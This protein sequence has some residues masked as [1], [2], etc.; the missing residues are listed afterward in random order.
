MPATTRTTSTTS[1]TSTTSTTSPR[2]VFE[3]LLAAITSRSWAELPD[4]YAEDSVVEQPFQLPAPLR[5]QG[6]AQLREHFAA[7]TRLPIEL[8]TRNVVV[9]ETLD[10][11]VVVGE[12]DYDVHLPATGRRFSVAN[13][14]VMRVRDGQIVASRDYHNHAVLADALRPS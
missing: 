11:E 10:P 1:S 8:S 5:L 7:A 13:V 12:Y 14:I 2:A 3:R 9:H 4:L 6:R